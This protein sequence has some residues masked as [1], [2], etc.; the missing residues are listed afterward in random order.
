MKHLFIVNPA[1]VG[2]KAKKNEIV[3][4]ISAFFADYPDIGYD[5]YMTRWKR[6]AV[7]YVR[8]YAL[9]SDEFV[10]VYAVGGTGT[11]FEVINGAIGLPN[12]QVACYPLGRR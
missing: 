11:L 12:V 4:K 9:A 5:I 10:R 3:G 8:R 7:G 1:S 2:V 6:D